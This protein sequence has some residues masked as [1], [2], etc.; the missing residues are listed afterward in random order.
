M[1]ILAS[2]VIDKAQKLLHDDGVRFPGEETMLPWLSDGLREAVLLKPSLGVTTVDEELVAGVQQSITG[3]SVEKF[4]YFKPVTLD[5]LN[6]ALPGWRGHTANAVVQFVAYD[7]NEPKIYYVYP[8]QPMD[9]TAI[10]P[11]SEVVSP[12]PLAAVSTAIPFEDLYAPALIDYLCHRCYQLE[13]DGESLARSDS[14]FSMFV[15]KIAGFKKP[16][17]ENRQSSGAR[18]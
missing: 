6:Q 14:F 12:T 11:I 9:T 16:A 3:V 4:I 17:Q 8:P 13:M 15:G 7:P 2:E 5:F 10:M 18:Q 1:T